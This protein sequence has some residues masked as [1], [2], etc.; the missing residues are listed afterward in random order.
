MIL[1][2][3]LS[4]TADILNATYAEIGEKWKGGAASVY[5]WSR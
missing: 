5:G 3:D 1:R 4:R 2:E